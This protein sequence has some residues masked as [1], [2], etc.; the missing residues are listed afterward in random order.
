MDWTKTTARRDDEHLS[1]RIWCGLYYKF[2][3]NRVADTR[4]PMIL[5]STHTAPRRVAYFKHLYAEWSAVIIDVAICLR[6]F[7]IVY[8]QAHATQGSA[9]RAQVKAGMLLTEWDHMNSIATDLRNHDDVIKW[10]HFPRY[11]PLVRGI[12]R[13]PV[14]SPHKGQ[15]R[16]A[17]MFSLVC[18]W[19]NGWVNNREAGDLRRYRTHYDVILMICRERGDDNVMTNK[20]DTC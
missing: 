14:N 10:K 2:D 13:S 15:W 17:L 9:Y 18:V 11:W 20:E 16:G 3:G 1:F 8:I 7:A 19:T 5:V 6:C 12:H 4:L